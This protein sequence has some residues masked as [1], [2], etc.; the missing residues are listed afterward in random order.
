MRNI[1]SAIVMIPSL[2]HHDALK[3]GSNQRAWIE[4]NN[5][6][7]EFN[8]SLRSKMADGIDHDFVEK[9]IDLKYTKTNH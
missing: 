5:E 1:T 7:L 8:K 4:T 2:K 6:L 9:V 3:N